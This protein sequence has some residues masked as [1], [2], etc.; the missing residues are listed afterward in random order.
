MIPKAINKT[1]EDRNIRPGLIN[2]L[3]R[4]NN[5]KNNTPMTMYASNV[6]AYLI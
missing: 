3:K 6:I 1:E 2:S 4:A 5:E